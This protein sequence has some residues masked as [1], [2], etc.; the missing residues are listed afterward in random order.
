MTVGTGGTL[1][2]D[3]GAPGVTDLYLGRNAIDTATWSR[4]VLDASA[5]TLVAAWMSW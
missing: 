3:A 2:L 1:T 5:G 4:G